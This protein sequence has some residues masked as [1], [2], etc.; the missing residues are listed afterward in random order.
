MY[1]Q[2]LLPQ[3]DR[4]RRCVTENVA[5]IVGTSREQSEVMELEGYYARPASIVVGAIHEL[6]RRRVLLTTPLRR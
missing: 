3:T 2:A 6:R 4:A 1:Q 5:N